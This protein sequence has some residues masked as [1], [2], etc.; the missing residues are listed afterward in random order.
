MACTYIGGHRGSC[1]YLEEVCILRVC[2][3]A[4]GR[5]LLVLCK[6]VQGQLWCSV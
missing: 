4:K 3:S 2:N 1:R 5:T 6:M